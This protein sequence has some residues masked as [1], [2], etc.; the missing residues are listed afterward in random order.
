MRGQE[1]EISLGLLRTSNK[2]AITDVTRLLRAAN[3]EGISVVRVTLKFSALG[4][5]D[6]SC[7]FLQLSSNGVQ[8]PVI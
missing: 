1:E 7:L 5:S 6:N 4:K 3:P 8:L 2:D